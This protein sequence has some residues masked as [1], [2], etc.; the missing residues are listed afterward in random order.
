ML[1]LVLAVTAFS[2][3]GLC[4]PA[5]GSSSSATEAANRL[6]EAT[7][8]ELEDLW[9]TSK[10][11]M[12]E[13][14]IRSEDGNFMG[15]TRLGRRVYA[16][17]RLITTG[18]LYYPPTHPVHPNRIVHVGVN[19][20]TK[21]RIYTV[22]PPNNIPVTRKVPGESIGILVGDKYLVADNVDPN[23]EIKHVP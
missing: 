6:R 14:Q 9:T 2:I 16:A 19:P 15:R 21:G 18:T 23:K 3:S 12:S 13:A 10:A 1:A 7:E 17:D 20:P 4:A 22:G 11:G 8:A 5:G